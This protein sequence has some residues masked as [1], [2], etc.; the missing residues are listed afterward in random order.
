MGLRRG[1]ANWGGGSCEGGGVVRGG[2]CEGEGGGDGR[3]G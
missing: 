1:V 3:G 2:I